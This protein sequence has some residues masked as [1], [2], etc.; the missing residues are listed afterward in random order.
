MGKDFIPYQRIERLT[1]DT[2]R[3][4]QRE[5]G[6]PL[7][8]PVDIDLIGEML[9]GIVWEY[10]L[11]D[12]PKTLAALFAGSRTVKLN[13]LHAKRFREKPG[14]ERFTKAHEIG[15]WILHVDQA[16]L[17]FGCLPG[18]ERRERVLCRNGAERPMERQ[19]DLYAAALLMPTDLLIKAA[20][21]YDLCRWPELYALAEA[22]DV[23]IT[24]LKIRLERLGLIHV[25]DDGVIYRSREERYGQ[26]RLF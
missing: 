19:A 9:Y 21:A 7:E 11:L 15:H 8:L 24:A 6:S 16:V 2:L 17:G 25:S 4:Y 23:T 10:D 5:T 13:D 26:Q 22:F 12:D 3:A 20:R 1:A 14:F 18:L